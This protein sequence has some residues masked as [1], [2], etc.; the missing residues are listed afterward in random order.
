MSYE[1]KSAFDITPGT[2]YEAYEAGTRNPMLPQANY[3]PRAAGPQ[4]LTGLG[5]H[6]YMAQLRQMRQPLRGMG[7][8]TIQDILNS[9]TGAAAAQAAP[10]I[11]NAM[12]P[13]MKV[14]LDEQFKPLT[15]TMT[16]MAAAA[17]AG[18]VFSFLA[19][20]KLTRG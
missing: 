3:R 2:A 10:I 18:G 17:V 9:A 7:D 6:S 20:Y 8:A 14:K 5:G 1:R 16:V 19:W 15:T 12:W 11:F 13:A 4:Y